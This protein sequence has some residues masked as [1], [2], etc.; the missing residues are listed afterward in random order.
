MAVTLSGTGGFFTRAGAAIAGVNEITALLGSTT[1]SRLS[2][3]ASQYLSNEQSDF[4]SAWSQRDSFRTTP[5]SYMQWLFDLVANTLIDQ[6]DRDTVLPSRDLSTALTELIRQMKAS[7]DSLNQPTLG[8]TVTAGSGN[9]GDTTIKI[10]TLDGD[11]LP[12]DCLFAETLIATVTS[13]SGAGSS[14]FS[15]SISVRG[16][17]AAS[18]TDYNWPQGSGASTSLTSTDPAV[19]GL[20]TNGNFETWTV[21]NV[22]DD[23]TISTGTAGTHV[24]R[25]ASPARS[26]DSYNLRLT[27]DGSTLIT[28]RQAPGTTLQPLTVYAATIT[29][30]INTVDATG[31]LRFALVDGSG[32][33][34]SDAQSTANSSSLGVNGGSGIGTSYTQFT[35]FFRTPAKVPATVFFELKVTT[36][37]TSGRTIDID[38]VQLAR[39][40]Q[41]YTGGPWAIAWSNVTSPVRGDYW[42]IAMTNSLGTESLVRSLDRMLNTR[43]LGL[44]FPT[45]GSETISDSLVA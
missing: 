22:P 10:S 45:A 7:G 6:V 39:P 2:T 5:T 24:T 23:W 44:K 12:L 25:Q 40:T 20:L 4:A 13:D 31:A 11:G 14:E 28:L 9:T 19:D 3:I 16:D 8:S 26:T 1:T 33:V 34:I 36:S 35:A 17:Q 32:T 30:K 38:L 21:T 43:S 15:E 27:S 41:L 29:A 18:P 37:P 42:T